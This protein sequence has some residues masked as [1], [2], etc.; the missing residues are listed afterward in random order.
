MK[1][2]QTLT[3][4]NK[5]FRTQLETQQREATALAIQHVLSRIFSASVDSMCQHQTVTVNRFS[6]SRFGTPDRV[7]SVELEQ[8]IRLVKGP[9]GDKGC[10]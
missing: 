3:A 6:R 9:R 5:D 4:E 2:N 1:E 8:Q 10:I 7:A